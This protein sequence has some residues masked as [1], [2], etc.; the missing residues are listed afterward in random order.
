MTPAADVEAIRAKA[1]EKQGRSERP[2]SSRGGRNSALDWTASRP[3][4]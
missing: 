3:S 1:A 2:G 4:Q